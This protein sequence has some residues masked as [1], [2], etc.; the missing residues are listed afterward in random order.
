MTQYAAQRA[1]LA[2]GQTMA[3]MM[4]DIAEVKAKHGSKYDAA[5]GQML[6]YAACLK[7]HKMIK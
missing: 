2:K 3:A 4:P 1:L 6:A 7:K 5:I